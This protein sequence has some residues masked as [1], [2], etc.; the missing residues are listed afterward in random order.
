MQGCEDPLYASIYPLVAKLRE[1]IGGAETLALA[2]YPGYLRSEPIQ[3]YLRS[4]TC[5]SS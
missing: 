5:G 1:R 3:R 2:D 4:L